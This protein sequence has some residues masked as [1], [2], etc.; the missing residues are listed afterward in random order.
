MGILGSQDTVS[1][2]CSL[3]SDEVCGPTE[4]MVFELSSNDEQESNKQKEMVRNIPETHRI[5][6][7]K[8]TQII[9]AIFW[10][11]LV[12]KFGSIMVIQYEK[13]EK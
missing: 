6:Q 5:A 10:K 2:V 7:V 3:A 1:N 4:A 13:R 8:T 12:V 11:L 9:Q